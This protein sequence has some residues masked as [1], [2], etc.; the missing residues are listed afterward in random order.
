MA[1]VQPSPWQN[2]SGSQ[3][4]RARLLLPASVDELAATVRAVAAG[5]EPRLRCVGSGHSF[6]P[7]WHDGA[8]LSLDRLSGVL[9]A[10]VTDR[11]ATVAAG[12]KLHDLGPMLWAHG[13]SLPQQGDIDRQSIAGALGTGTH[14]TGRRLGNLSSYLREVT[15]ITAGGE[16]L[17]LSPESSPEAFS[18]AQVS[19]GTLGVVVSVKLALLPAFNLHERTWDSS[20]AACEADLAALVES[21]RHFEF[22]WTPRTDRC[23]M[24]TLNPTSAAPVDLADGEYV[25]PAYRAFP[26]EREVRFN[27][28]EYSVPFAEGWECFMELRAMMLEKFSKLPWPV[29]F[30]TLAADDAMLSTAHHRETVTLSVHQG[31]E[32]D[33]RPLFDAAEAI[34]RNHRGR[35]HWGKLHGLS[36]AELASLY[37][38]LGRFRAVRQ[39]LDPQGLFLND[40]LRQ[41]LDP[42]P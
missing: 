11:T 8:L 30:R 14:G 35:P 12:T 21:N 32:R 31:A 5:P 18:A 42:P 4:H 28:M 19:L 20:I 17:T 24:K 34:F 7:F 23:E 25:A 40:Y 6:V 16:S 36:A 39:E 9:S 1:A 29:E 22:F 2:W 10:D 41:L 37:P 26:S 3:Q 27:E 13:L 15:L 38:M 33:F